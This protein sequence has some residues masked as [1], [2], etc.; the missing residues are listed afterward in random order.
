MA[1]RRIYPEGYKG[2]RYIN[3]AVRRLRKAG[4]IT[5]PTVTH[6]GKQLLP[7]GSIIMSGERK[8]E[9]RSYKDY[10]K[11]FIENIEPYRTGTR[12]LKEREYA[13]AVTDF[14]KAFSSHTT[15][16][17]VIEPVNLF[18][19]E[20][21]ESYFYQ[22]AIYIL[23]RTPTILIP[24][25]EVLKMSKEDIRRIFKIANE[26]KEELK[27]ESKTGDMTY[28]EIINMVYDDLSSGIMREG[29]EYI[30]I[31]DKSGR[32]E[33]ELTD[34]GKNAYGQYRSLYD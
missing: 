2:A 24:R 19:V 27:Y 4:D 17:E 33:Y 25:D 22:R 31:R 11:Y 16:K 13:E 14:V 28:Y 1:K 5:P 8:G 26:I 12:V 32:I 15:E 20:G 21:Q 30:E 10:R 29:S 18:T 7:T 23:T 6:T 3:T 34:E 9:I